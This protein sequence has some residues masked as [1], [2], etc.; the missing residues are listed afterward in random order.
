MI[1]A[2]DKLY[3]EKAKNNLGVMLDYAT[4]DL[5]YNLN[6][7]WNIFINSSI[8]KKF[9]NGDVNIIAG[10]SGI[11]IVYDLLGQS[12]IKPK[13]TENRS[14]EYWVGWAIA[15]YQ[16]K[17]N[18]SFKKIDSYVSIN[19]ILSLYS[20]YH[21]MDINSFNDKLNDFIRLR[22]ES[23]LKRIRMKVGLSQS[24]LSLLSGVPVRTI[25]QYEQKRKNIN[26]A[27][28]NYLISLSKVL[29]CSIEDLLEI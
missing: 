15:Y 9:E 26:N 14:K 3:L 27:Q 7:F 13:F 28:V 17:N 20:P 21:E 16:W 2:Y 19:E 23:N 12:D 22:K 29:Y 5:N 11:E 10:K 18:I 24:K 6:E 1:S 4:Y 8:A 25:Q